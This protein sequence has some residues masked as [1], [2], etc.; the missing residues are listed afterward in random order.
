MNFDS[1]QDEAILAEIGRRLRRQRLNANLTRATLAE[2]IGLSQDTVR[3]AED[4]RN[5]SVESLIR[6]LRGLDRLD[7]LNDL[8]ADTGPSPVA[9]ARRRG[10]L[11]QRASGKRATKEGRDWQW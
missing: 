11:R 6:V 5:V 3:N 8:A 1:M 10:R 7:Q 2:R 4:G 9:L